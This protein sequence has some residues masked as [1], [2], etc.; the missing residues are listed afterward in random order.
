MTLNDQE[1]KKIMSMKMMITRTT[2]MTIEAV[3]HADHHSDLWMYRFVW[4]FLGNVLSDL[5]DSMVS[6]SNFL[7]GV[8][9][10]ATEDVR[11]G[12]ICLEYLGIMVQ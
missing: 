3:G 12:M 1:Q 8:C 11:C 10:E 4:S 6:G 9:L 2:A 7:N 5:K